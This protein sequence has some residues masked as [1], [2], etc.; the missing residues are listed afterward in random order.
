MTVTF[1][2]LQ[3][4]SYSLQRLSSKRYAIHNKM[5]QQTDFVEVPFS[6]KRSTFPVGRH[7]W[8]YVTA[9]PGFHSVSQAKS[10]PDPLTPFLRVCYPH[11]FF[12][13]S[14]SWNIFPFLYPQPEKGAPFGQGP[15]YGQLNWMPGV[16]LGRKTKFFRE[17]AANRDTWEIFRE[18]RSNVVK[19]S[20]RLTFLGEC[21]PKIRDDTSDFWEDFY[22]LIHMVLLK[23]R[24]LGLS[25]P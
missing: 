9:D 8:N 10:C 13:C 22:F 25:P 24:L 5:L 1:Q 7:V 4:M 18:T 2:L 15:Q 14:N 20:G 23:Q 3:K 6:K 17:F 11:F 16:C 19:I 21:L 12:L